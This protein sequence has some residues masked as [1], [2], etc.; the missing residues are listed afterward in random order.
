MSARQCPRLFEVEA[1]RDGRLTGAERASFERH[2]AICA[3]CSG[4]MRALQRLASALR[5]SS[6]DEIGELHVRRER[7]RLLAAFNGA[8]IGPKRRRVSPVLACGFAAAL[9]AVALLVRWRANGAAPSFAA[10]A[11]VV[12]AD[13]DAI[14]SSRTDGDREWIVLSRGALSIH[15]DHPQGE[16]PH[17]RQRAEPDTG[18]GRLI[19]V[20]PD[21]ELEDIGTTFT[22]SADADHTTRVAVAEGRV[23][24]RL[25][26][27]P[28]IT[29]GPGDSWV[30]ETP[31]PVAC[32]T[33]PLALPPS[34]EPAP[35]EPSSHPARSPLPPSSAGAPGDSSSDFRAAIDALERG[36]SRQAAALFAEFLGKHPGDRRTEDAAYLRAIALQRC[37]DAVGTKDAAREYLRRYPYGF[38]R[39]EMEQLSR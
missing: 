11:V 23:L 9:V 17:A 6:R 20:L 36:D 16:A 14:W 31:A 12:R 34:A 22:V 10:P 13:G 37:G 25:R 1:T 21:G 30:R 2:V 28:Q 7:T 27:R 18:E 35:R 5:A 19:V 24:L 38:R 15:V 3:V 29:M 32:A 33:A 8:L 4:E 26:G 39:L